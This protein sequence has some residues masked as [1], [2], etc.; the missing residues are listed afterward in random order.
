MTWLGF[1]QTMLTS[2]SPGRMT[3]AKNWLVTPAYSIFSSSRA[4]DDGFGGAEH[5]ALETADLL[6]KWVLSS[7]APEEAGVLGDF[8]EVER[9][10][11]R[12]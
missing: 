11:P 12:R 6:L 2:G 1:A 7:L 3:V 9:R 5:A 4:G 10:R 8:A